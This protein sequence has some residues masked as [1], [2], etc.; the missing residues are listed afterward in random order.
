M[1][2]KLNLSLERRKYEIL[3]GETHAALFSGCKTK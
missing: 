2:R 3:C 1:F